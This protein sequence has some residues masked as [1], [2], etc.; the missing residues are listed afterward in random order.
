MKGSL[1]VAL[2]WGYI[3]DDWAARVKLRRLLALC[4]G[5]THG[6]QRTVNAKLAGP[7]EQP[8]ASMSPR[9]P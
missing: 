1:D 9:K 8:T 4:W 6:P 7:R 2:A 5:L 3:A